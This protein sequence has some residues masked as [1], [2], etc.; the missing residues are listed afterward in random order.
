MRYSSSKLFFFISLNG[1]QDCVVEVF[2]ALVQ[3]FET[4]QCVAQCDGRVENE[5]GLGLTDTTKLK[6]RVVIPFLL[7]LEQEV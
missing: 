4:E 6:Y 2:I 7:F 5:K 3:C 1:P